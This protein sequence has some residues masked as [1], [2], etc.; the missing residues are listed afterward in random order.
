MTYTAKELARSFRKTGI[1]PC[2]LVDD[3]GSSY[4]A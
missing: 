3:A 2:F 4:N 1:R